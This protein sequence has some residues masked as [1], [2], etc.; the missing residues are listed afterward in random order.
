M[1]HSE[2]PQ[3]GAGNL[4]KRFVSHFCKELKQSCPFHDERNTFRPITAPARPLTDIEEFRRSKEFFLLEQAVICSAQLIQKPNQKYD[5]DV[6]DGQK[7]CKR[8]L[9]IIEKLHEVYCNSLAKA[10]NTLL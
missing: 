10:I 3:N 8:F 7:M 6:I 9:K 5:L 2:K 1:I 4:I